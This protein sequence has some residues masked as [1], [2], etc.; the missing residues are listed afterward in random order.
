MKRTKLDDE[1]DEILDKCWNLLS[2]INEKAFKD[3]QPDIVSASCYLCELI[4]T[5]LSNRTEE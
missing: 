4:E 1:F 3:E 5:V 2:D